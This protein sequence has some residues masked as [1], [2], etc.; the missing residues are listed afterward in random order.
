[1][2]F[3]PDLYEKLGLFYLGRRTDAPTVPVLYDSRDLTTHAMC[4]GMTGSGKTGLCV[5]LVEEAAIDDIPVIVIDPKGDLSNLLLTFPDLDGEKLEEWVDENEARRKGMSKREFADAEA[6]KWTRGL[7]AWGQSLDR[8]RLLHDS[9]DFRI[10]TP[11]SNAG[12]PVSMLSS[13]DRPTQAIVDEPDLFSDRIESTVSGLLGLMGIDADPLQS[14]EHVLLSNILA[15]TW[16]AGQDLDLPSLI[17][18]I[19]KPPFDKVGVMPLDDV[20]GSG[21]RSKLAMRLNNLVAAPTFRSWLEGD[22]LDIDAFLHS[23]QGKPR[24]SI[25]S[26]AHLSEPER[27][28]FVSLLLDAIVGW[29]RTQSGSTSLRAMVYMDEI[30]GY[31][32]PVANPPSKKPMM[33][34]LKQARAFGV[35]MVLAT[36]NPVDMDYKA[37]S[38]CGTWFLGRLQTDR[39]RQRVIDGLGEGNPSLDPAAARTDFDELLNSLEARQFLLHN[40]HEPEPISFQTRWVMSYLKGPMTRDDI[41]RAMKG[42]ESEGSK[43]RVHEEQATP[44]ASKPPGSTTDERPVSTANIKEFF[45]P[46]RVVKPQ[47]GKLLWRPMIYGCGR[48]FF[49]DEKLDVSRHR[50]FGYITAID[51]GPIPVDWVRAFRVDYPPEK[52]TD[53]PGKEGQFLE[54]PTSAFDEDAHDDWQKALVDHVYRTD[55]VV[56]QECKPLKI[57]S[58]PDESERDFMRRA[59][60]AIKELRDDALDELQEKYDK[61]ID[62]ARK[63][64]RKLEERVE[65]EESQLRSAGVDTALSFGGSIFDA[66]TGRSARSAVR[67]SVSKVSRTSREK[68]DVARAEEAL[69]DEHADLKDLER[70]FK[71]EASRL[72]ETYALENYAITQKKVDPLKRD[73]ELQLFGLCWVPYWQH[74]DGQRQRAL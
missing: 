46:V 12:L 72:A 43:T 63:N 28:F 36:Q 55:R 1:M 16:G 60:D 34:L 74:S 53:A 50:L 45:L 31:L 69:A 19:Q 24:V 41:R 8:I 35:G 13:L 51:D 42:I 52:F 14:G 71:E 20:F 54:C 66:F 26:I 7:E 3:S 38:N 17:R 6:Q 39:D 18:M 65:R 25:F 27:M 61:R 59:K 9:A 73:I 49:E 44:E 70:E 33:T 29:M 22:P 57:T 30:A 5:G 32:P 2:S 11:G 4:V 68:D 23:P 15:H 48:T 40:V 62:R 47:G 58:R 56:L 10:Y 37:L 67:R 21:D 64:I